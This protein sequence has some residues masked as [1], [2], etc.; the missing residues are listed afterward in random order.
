MRRR[1]IDAA[2][3]REDWFLV[4]LILVAWC[5]TRMT[6]SIAKTRYPSC[7]GHFTFCTPDWVSEEIKISPEVGTWRSSPLN[8]MSKWDS[9]KDAIPFE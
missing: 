2:W 1:F 5:H 4:S 6:A 8:P 7:L 9:W 3:V